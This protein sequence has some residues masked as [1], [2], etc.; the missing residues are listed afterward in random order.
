[1]GSAHTGQPARFLF[2]MNSARLAVCFLGMVCFFA[3]M[4]HSR[5]RVAVPIRATAT[6]KAL[7]HQACRTDTTD[8]LR[9][10]PRSANGRRRNPSVPPD[11]L[12]H[13]ADRYAVRNTA[14]S[15]RIPLSS[16]HHPVQ[17]FVEPSYQADARNGVLI[18]PVERGLV[19]GG[20]LQTVVYHHQRTEPHE[21][22]RETQKRHEVDQ[23][24]DIEVMP[25]L[26][27]GT[28]NEQEDGK[29]GE[30]SG[31]HHLTISR[32]ALTRLSHPLRNRSE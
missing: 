17:P 14:R 25:F 7:R 24:A 16:G 26:E 18:Q 5:L 15:H 29:C 21:R 10:E 30:D 22:R 1:M 3:V 11:R 13:F 32:K 12:P 19:L 2:S 8:N 23:R 27:G 6:A 9:V 4:A 28:E 20:V 31:P